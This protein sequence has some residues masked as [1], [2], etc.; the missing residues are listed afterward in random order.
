M[1][2]LCGKSSESHITCTLYATS[3]IFFKKL[4]K[5][6]LDMTTHS[7]TM[8]TDLKEGLLHPAVTTVLWIVCMKIIQKRHA[9]LHE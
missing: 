7:Y 1:R 9:V 6:I 3:Y 5:K 8:Y 2:F 4:C